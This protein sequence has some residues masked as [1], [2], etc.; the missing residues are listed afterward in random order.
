[1]NQ[2]TRYLLGAGILTVIALGAIWLIGSARVGAQESRGWRPASG[3]PAASAWMRI[4]AEMTAPDGVTHLCHAF[5]GPPLRDASGAEVRPT[6]MFSLFMHRTGPYLG[7]VESA[8]L[9]TCA[10]GSPVSHGGGPF[11]GEGWVGQGRKMASLSPSGGRTWSTVRSTEDLEL[12][13]SVV[14]D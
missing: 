12:A 8:S 4:E 6:A 14:P 3:P 5:I 2:P 7:L 9:A 1:M 13:L 10:E 11:S